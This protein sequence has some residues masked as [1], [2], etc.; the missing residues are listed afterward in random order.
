MP[1]SEHI[2]AP[3]AEEAGMLPKAL[4][5]FINAHTKGPL[6]IHLFDI[7]SI[8]YFNGQEANVGTC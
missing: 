4:I 2:H 7:I 3:T 6:P 1:P 8:L 5:I